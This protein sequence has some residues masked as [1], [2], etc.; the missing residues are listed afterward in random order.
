MGIEENGEIG[1]GDGVGAGAWPGDAL[2]GVSRRGRLSKRIAFMF[3]RWR[4]LRTRWLFT[5][6]R[7]LAKTWRCAR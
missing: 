3:P 5:T 7:G 4:G 2:V 1:G 6:A